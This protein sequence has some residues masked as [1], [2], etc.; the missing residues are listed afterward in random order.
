M[1]SLLRDAGE[2]IGLLGP[3]LGSQLAELMVTTR[4]K[5]EQ[6]K[7]IGMFVNV[8]T[9]ATRGDANLMATQENDNG[10]VTSLKVPRNLPDSNSNGDKLDQQNMMGYPQDL[11]AKTGN[12]IVGDT[13]GSGTQ[14][15]RRRKKQ[16]EVQKHSYARDTWRASLNTYKL[17]ARE[18]V[19]FRPDSSERLPTLSVATARSSLLAI[20]RQALFNIPYNA[21]SDHQS[22]TLSDRGAD[23]AYITPSRYT[24]LRNDE[25]NVLLCHDAYALVHKIL[26]YRNVVR[27]QVGIGARGDTQ[28]VHATY[29]E[30]KTLVDA[31]AQRLEDWDIDQQ[32][33]AH[34]LVD[35]CFPILRGSRQD[36]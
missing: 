24:S 17:Y 29:E 27:G 33:E 34:Y 32:E 28:R 35:H 30:C 25:G 4:K 3:W 6:N 9:V 10:T 26:Q 8:A 20:K 18:A 5:M 13:I 31:V 21:F 7:T 23:A 14:R 16:R 19:N 22:V 11:A 2:D 36:K 1:L 15:Q 12:D